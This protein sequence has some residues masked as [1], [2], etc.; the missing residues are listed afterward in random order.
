M[1]IQA[2][3]NGVAKAVR[4]KKLFHFMIKGASHSLSQPPATLLPQQH[5][6]HQ[7]RLDIEI[8]KEA[9]QYICFFYSKK[10]RCPDL[11]GYQIFAGKF[12]IEIL[13]SKAYVIID[14]ALHYITR[15]VHKLSQK[16]FISKKNFA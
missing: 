10:Q 1:Y 7:N 4:H 12:V 3:G 13:Y 14:Q 8:E 16:H 11:V 6:P 9:N 5:Q 15:Y 2:R